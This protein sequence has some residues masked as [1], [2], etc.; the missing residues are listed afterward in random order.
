MKKMVSVLG[1]GFA[2]LMVPQAANAQQMSDM[3]PFSEFSV[4]SVNRAVAPGNITAQAA[5]LGDGSNVIQ[6]VYDGIVMNVEPR[7]CDANGRGCQAAVIRSFFDVPPDVP[8]AALV[9]AVDNFNRANA[10]LKASVVGQNR[11]NVSRYQSAHFGVH[12]GTVRR[13]YANFSQSFN[14]L[15]Q[16]YVSPIV[17]AR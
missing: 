10:F 15:V 4:D 7:E 12:Y 11:V 13:E 16:Q 5:R 6:F 14:L 9:Q 17:G 3:A 2:A 1:A 8:V